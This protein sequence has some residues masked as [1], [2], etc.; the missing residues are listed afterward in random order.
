MQ[1]IATTKVWSGP[2]LRR[3]REARALRQADLAPRVGISRAALAVVEGKARPSDR[4]V[5]RYLRAI[6]AIARDVAE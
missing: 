3:L 4:D 6:N 1:D 2:D 5:D